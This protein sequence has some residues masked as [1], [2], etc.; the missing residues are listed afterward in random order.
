MARPRVAA[1]ARRRRPRPHAVTALPALDGLGPA[2]ASRARCAA[3]ADRA[4]APG[5][6]RVARV[7][8]E[9]RVASPGALGA[10]R[11]QRGGARPRDSTRRD[12]FGGYPPACGRAAARGGGGPPPAWPPRCPARAVLHAGPDPP[13]GPPPRRGGGAPDP[14]LPPDGSGAARARG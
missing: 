7:A 9:R 3:R 12:R 4:G 11:L 5:R 14:V 13:R 8:L 10:P 2:A 1:R 6:R